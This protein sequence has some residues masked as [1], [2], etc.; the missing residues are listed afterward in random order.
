MLESCKG[1]L[2][3]LRECN[4]RDFLVWVFNRLFDMKFIYVCVCIIFIYFFIN[5]YDVM[6]WFKDDSV[7]L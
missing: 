3:C 1:I 2:V 4:I 5:Y 7:I 6:Y